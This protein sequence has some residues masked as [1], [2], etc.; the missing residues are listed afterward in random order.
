M[1]GCLVKNILNKFPCLDKQ[2]GGSPIRFYPIGPNT[3]R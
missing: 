2:G 3:F 1:G